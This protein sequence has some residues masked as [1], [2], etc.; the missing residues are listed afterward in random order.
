MLSRPA[1]GMTRRAVTVGVVWVDMVVSPGV[2]GAAR[3]R[4]GCLTSRERAA[5]GWASEWAYCG[6]SR[7]IN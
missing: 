5:G 4:A 1:T 6:P 7:E 2:F 3:C